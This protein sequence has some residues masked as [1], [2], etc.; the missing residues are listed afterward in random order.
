M[1]CVWL[2]TTF[3][4][5]F[6]CCFLCLQNRHRGSGLWEM[7]SRKVENSWHT[8]YARCHMR[9]RLGGG[10]LPAA[11]RR[12]KRTPPPTL[13]PVPVGR[14]VRAPAPLRPPAPSFLFINTRPC[15]PRTPAPPIRSPLGVCCCIAVPPV[16]R[17]SVIVGHCTSCTC[18]KVLDTC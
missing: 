16:E 8:A 10:L 7:G 14:V 1:E 6:S 12:R 2:A 17:R 15:V 5:A 13:T 3:C 4:Y 18:T 11:G 9:R